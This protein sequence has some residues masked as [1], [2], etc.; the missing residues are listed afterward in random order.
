MDLMHN[1]K[2]G[3]AALAAHGA[4]LNVV[5]ALAQYVASTTNPA[6]SASGIRSRTALLN[7]LGGMSE[8][9][10]GGIAGECMCVG[11]WAES[12]PVDRRLVHAA[13]CPDSPSPSSAFHNPHAPGYRQWRLGAK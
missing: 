2:G 3:L 1:V 10:M 8:L 11:R 7:D 9:E 6:S 4:S 13:T 12:Q 5:H